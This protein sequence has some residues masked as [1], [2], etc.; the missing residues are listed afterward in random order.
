MQP[1]PKDN[2]ETSVKHFLLA[3]GGRVDG[4]DMAKKIQERIGSFI[5]TPRVPT[6]VSRAL[7]QDL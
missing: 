1:D 6:I 2:L 5:G 3:L 7:A 4:P